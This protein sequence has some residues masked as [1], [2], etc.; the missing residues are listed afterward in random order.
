[1]NK[2]DLRQDILAVR[3]GLRP[4]WRRDFDLRIAEHVSELGEY[5]RASTVLFYVSFRSEVDTHGLMKAAWDQG[6][7]VA[8]PRVVREGNRLDLYV[9]ES[10]DD[11]SPGAMGILEPDPGRTKTCPT[12]EVNLIVIPGAVFDRKGHRIGYGGG[13]YDRLLARTPREAFRVGLAYGRQLVEEI[14]AESH[15]E[16]LDLVVTEDGLI[17]TDR[18]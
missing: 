11:L 7:R 12:D 8:V 2:A 5:V 10:M 17:Y 4:D 6:K 16:K 3:N 13:Y 14:P 15:D 9:I 1:V 18:L